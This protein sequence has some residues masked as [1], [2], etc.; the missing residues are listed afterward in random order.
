MI[1][2]LQTGRR[3]W[4]GRH[5]GAGVQDRLPEPGSELVQGD[6]DDQCGGVDAVFGQ[7]VDR[8]MLQQLTSGPAEALRV[9]QHLRVGIVDPLRRIA[10]PILTG[11]VGPSWAAGSGLVPPVR[12]EHQLR[13]QVRWGGL[14]VAGDWCGRPGSC[15]TGRHTS[16][17]SGRRTGSSRPR[18]GETS[19]PPR[20]GPGSPPAPT[21][22][23]A[24]R[25]HRQG[26]PPPTHADTPCSSAYDNACAW[27][28]RS[29]CTATAR[30]NVT[31]PDSR[32]TVWAIS[33]ACSAQTRSPGGAA[34]PPDNATAWSC[35]FTLPYSVADADLWQRAFHAAGSR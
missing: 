22:R 12:R 15:A 25:R 4:P 6:G 18:T 34:A 32:C 20:P 2:A 10:G 9:R 21:R 13:R 3:T 35:G 19:T 7:P 33:T 17:G 11:R 30:L 29:S 31:S 23:Q 5:R 28:T 26:R 1:A 14:L 24:G 8:Q 27:P 16:S